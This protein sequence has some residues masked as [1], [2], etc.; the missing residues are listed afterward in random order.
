MEEQKVYLGEVGRCDGGV[1]PSGRL[2]ALTV[3]PCTSGLHSFIKRGSHEAS[4]QCALRSG[5]AGRAPNPIT[6]V[7]PSNTPDG[8][9]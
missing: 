2:A 4:F 7:N 3:T 8:L 6:T 9:L 5:C 1:A